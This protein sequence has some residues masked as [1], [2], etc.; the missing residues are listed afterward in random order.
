MTRSISLVSTPMSERASVIGVRMMRNAWT[1]AGWKVLADARVDQHRRLGMANQ[2]RI[3]DNPL[4][5]SNSLRGQEA[6]DQESGDD[7]SHG[8]L[9]RRTELGRR[10]ARGGYATG[11]M[12]G[13]CSVV[14]S[15]TVPVAAGVRTRQDRRQDGREQP[16]NSRTA[17][18]GLRAG[19][20]P[21]SSASRQAATEP[22]QARSSAADSSAG[23]MPVSITMSAIDAYR[24]SRT[25]HRIANPRC[26]AALEPGTV[27]GAEGARLDGRGVGSKPDDDPSGAQALTVRGLQDGAGGHTDHR[28][29]RRLDPARQRPGL[30]LAH[31]HL[32][33]LGQDLARGRA[34][35]SANELVVVDIRPAGRLRHEPADRRLPAPHHA[36]EKDA[37]RAPDAHRRVTSPGP[38]RS[39]V[40]PRLQA[41]AGGS[42]TSRL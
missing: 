19:G 26:A 14:R 22:S 4:A 38:A 39:L 36:D 7:R 37:A 30:R 27:V 12:D 9:W 42:T 32:A 41:A 17:G 33:A 24:G 2:P 34:V 18:R 16:T 8:Q 11:V 25:A 35:R 21:A 3:H 13:R 40:V 20:L 28:G 23:F 1:S 29:S 31:L 6:A 15:D 10:D 5:G